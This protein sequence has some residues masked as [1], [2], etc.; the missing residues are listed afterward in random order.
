MKRAHRGQTG[1]SLAR[2]S[3]LS[4]L[5]YLAMLEWIW[6]SGGQLAK[7]VVEWPNSRA[8]RLMQ[9][10]IL[11]GATGFAAFE[12]ID[13]SL[14]TIAS[15]VPPALVYGRIAC[16][17]LTV[18]C[19]ALQF[20][21]HSWR[22]NDL[23][24]VLT[25]PQVLAIISFF[26]LTFDAIDRRHEKRWLLIS[27]SISL[28]LAVDVCVSVAAGRLVFFISQRTVVD[29]VAARLFAGQIAACVLL[30]VR[31]TRFQFPCK[32]E[33]AQQKPAGEQR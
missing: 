1:V 25:V 4:A 32:D 31:T 5:A 19:L 28:I 15:R 6:G 12:A 16:A 17:S 7:S 27:A 14:R 9:L 24:L 13:R 3:L 8:I 18:T 22:I 23:V 30:L 11:T 21:L 10:A 26:H 33:S 29:G 20:V 2:F